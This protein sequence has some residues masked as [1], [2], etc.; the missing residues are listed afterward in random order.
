MKNLLTGIWEKTKW[1]LF[2]IIW[3]IGILGWGYFYLEFS[4]IKCE[5]SQTWSEHIERLNSDGEPVLE[6]APQKTESHAQPEEAEAVNTTSAHPSIEDII[7]KYFKDDYQMAIAIAKAESRLNPLAVH[8]NRNGTK[9]V[10][11]FQINDCHR[12]SVEDRKNPERNVEIAFEIYQR[13]GWSPWSVW[14][15]NSY[16]K[17]L[18]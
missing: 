15:N 18:N 4:K 11:I 17:F 8:T 13:S 12:F 1:G 5:A 2:L 7:R 16:Q 3:S 10:G 6:V 9:D 14:H